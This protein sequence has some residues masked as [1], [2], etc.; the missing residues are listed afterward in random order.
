MP[1][2]SSG[3]RKIPNRKK[4]LE[5]VKAELSNKQQFPLSLP[6]TVIPE[7]MIRLFSSSFQ[8]NLQGQALKEENP[9]EYLKQKLKIQVKKNMA[10]RKYNKPKLKR[11]PK[12][13]EQLSMANLLE[14]WESGV[15]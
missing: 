13:R 14:R 9:K 7:Q 2:L 12:S 8:N 15:F 1:R 6:K 10:T 3:T 5:R 11:R 4:E